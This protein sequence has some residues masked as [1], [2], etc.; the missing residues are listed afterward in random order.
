MLADPDKILNRASAF[1]KEMEEY[2]KKL[3]QSKA[4]EKGREQEKLSEQ[5]GTSQAQQ[6]KLAEQGVAS[7]SQQGQEE[8]NFLLD[9]GREVDDWMIRQKVNVTDNL[10]ERIAKLAVFVSPERMQELLKEFQSERLRLVGNMTEKLD[11]L[12]KEF[13]AYPK[14]V[15]FLDKKIDIEANGFKKM[16]QELQK[17]EEKLHKEIQKR[18]DYPQNKEQYEKERLE[19]KAD[20]GR[21]VSSCRKEKQDLKERVKSNLETASEMAQ[22][23]MDETGPDYTGGDD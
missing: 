20:L 13:P 5:A 23:L 11:K 10:E 19:W 18:S 12:E 22:D 9:R 15:A 21:E 14:P 17:E 8:R 1:S 2:K 4:M 7:H 3:G 6:D 16:T